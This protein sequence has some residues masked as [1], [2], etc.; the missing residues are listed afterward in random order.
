[1]C[2]LFACA[3]VAYAQTTTA[4]TAT[5]PMG[6]VGRRRRVMQMCNCLCERRSA[7]TLEIFVV[8]VADGRRVSLDK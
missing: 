1:M 4:E 7:S 8:V 3:N 2:T 5:A 6:E